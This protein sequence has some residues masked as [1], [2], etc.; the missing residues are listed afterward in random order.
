MGKEEILQEILNSFAEE[1][2][3][4]ARNRMGVSESNYNP[5]CLTGTCFTTEELSVMP[6][7]ELN[8][9]IKLA[10]HATEAFY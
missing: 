1:A 7:V 2:D 10:I 9:L 5:Y 6:E 4:K 8:N 3:N